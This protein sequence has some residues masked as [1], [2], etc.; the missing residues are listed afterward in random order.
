[1]RRH[2]RKSLAGMT[3]DAHNHAGVSINA[4]RG[5]SGIALHVFGHNREAR[6]LYRKLG[7]VATNINLYKPVPGAC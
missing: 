3:I 6:A 2:T 4:G 7:Y 1:M 5:L